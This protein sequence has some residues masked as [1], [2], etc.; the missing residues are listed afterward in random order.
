M[1]LYAWVGEDELGSGKVGLK[2]GLVPAGM[3]PLVAMDYDLHKL[4]PMLSQMEDQATCYGKK[5][6]L[7]KFVSSE[8]IVETKAGR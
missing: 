3:I 4:E 6:R 5:I 2:R 1:I 7:M 8:V